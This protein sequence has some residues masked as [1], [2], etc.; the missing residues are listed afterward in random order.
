MAKS[1][2]YFDH[3]YNARNDQKILEL[4]SE[5][6][7]EGYGI[8]FALIEV[9]CESDGRIKRGALGGLSLGLSM[10][11]ATIEKMI[12]FM[13]SI[14]LF[15]E[16]DGIIYSKRINNHLQFRTMLSES[17][18]KGGRGNKKP[19]FSPP[20]APLE[21]PFS[22]PLAPLEA[23]KESIGKDSKGNKSKRQTIIFVKPTVE[24]IADY[25]NERKNGISP[26]R[27]Y[28]YYESNGWLVGRNKMKDWKASVRTWEKNNN[29]KT[30][31]TPLPFTKSTEEFKPNYPIIPFD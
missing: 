7:W 4:R 12:N 23:G 26:S 6:G 18:K 14:E 11:K 17:G 5:F 2:F 22:P 10:D 29:T 19:P 15:N 8:Y 27:F 30:V 1:S 3:D 16:V 9:L 25:C 31:S 21:A 24:Q 13:V 28:D 20:L